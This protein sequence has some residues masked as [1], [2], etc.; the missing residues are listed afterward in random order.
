MLIYEGGGAL[1]LKICLVD[2][3]LFNNLVWQIAFGCGFVSELI[4]KAAA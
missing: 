4:C 2:S 3:V 1:D